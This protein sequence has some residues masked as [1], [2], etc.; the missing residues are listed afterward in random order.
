MACVTNKHVTN[1]I[2]DSCCFPHKF[3]LPDGVGTATAL[4]LAGSQLPAETAIH[5]MLMAQ[6]IIRYICVSQNENL[7]F[8]FFLLY[9][10]FQLR[11][12]KTSYKP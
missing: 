7:C 1:L 5:L 6:N 10:V 3:L 2:K 8:F 12:T 9:A 11:K 4:K